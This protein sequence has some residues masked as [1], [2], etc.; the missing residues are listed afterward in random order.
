M[1]FVTSDMLSNFMFLSTRGN[2]AFWD[3]W[4]GEATVSRELSTSVCAHS[5][6]FKIHGLRDT[7][8]SQRC[9]GDFQHL[10]WKPASLQLTHVEGTNGS[11]SHKQVHFVE[12]HGE[13]SSTGQTG[14]KAFLLSPIRQPLSEMNMG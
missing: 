6:N 7:A 13:R 10:P 2:V 12:S 14:A 3:F 11:E 8:L 9:S 4:G 5:D 1:F